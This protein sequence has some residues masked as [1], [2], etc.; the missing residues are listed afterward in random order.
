M[1]FTVNALKVLERRYLKKDDDGRPIERPEDMFWRVAY[2]IA[3]VDKDYNENADVLAVAKDFFFL[4]ANMEFMPNSPTLMNA[5][6]ELG[7]LSA[8]FVLPVE[9][10]M[11]SI[12]EAVKNTALIHKSG[13]GTGFSFSRIRP[14]NDMVLSTKGI[15]SGPI[16]FMKVFDMATET[17]KQGGTRRGAN[18]GI[19]RVDHPDILEFIESKENESQLNNFNISVAVTD[20]FME[21]CESDGEYDLINPRTREAVGRLKAREVFQKIV[22]HAWLNG[23]P[24]IIFLDRIN[25][26]NPTPLVGQ[27]ESTNPCGEQPLLPYESCNLGS[28]NLEKML[29]KRNSHYEVDFPRLART[30]RTAVHFLDNVIDTNKYPLPK[31]AEMTRANRKIGLGVMGFADMLIR[32]GIPY[33]SE[34]ALKVADELMAFIQNKAHDESARIAETRGSFPNYDKSIYAGSGRPMRNATV[35]TVA[36]TGTI[37]IIS[38][39][40]SGIEPI[41]AIAFTRHVLDN[42]ELI[43]AHPIFRQLAK[44][45][46]FFSPQLMK[47]IAEAGGMADLPE[48]PP[49]IKGVFVTAH[50]VTPEWHIKMQAAFQVH[51]DNAV[52]KTVNFANSATKEDVEN[53]YTLAYKLGCKGVTIFRDGSRSGQVWTKSITKGQAAPQGNDIIPRLRQTVT[54]GTTEKVVIG[55]GNLYVTVNSDEIG[56]CEVFTSTGRA[57]GCPSQSEATSRLVSLALRSGISV[58]A[59]IEQLKG[60]RC[61][62]TVA[63]KRINPDIRCLSCPDAIG[64]AIEKYSKI[65]GRHA[66]E[67]PNGEVETEAAVEPAT[68]VSA[69][70]DCG[71]KI[72]REGGCIVCRMCGYSKCN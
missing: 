47:K 9:D 2:T 26:G 67:E 70:P 71:A 16:S 45:R 63:A 35:T 37:S 61:L 40:S 25:K 36:P 12:F 65:P 21:A 68:A 69:C 31:I 19:L 14:K 24:G 8:C 39:C 59:L 66:I 52:S 3:Q 11:E 27:I 64:R 55:C 6:R 43:E 41:F 18:M 15:S 51:T 7:Q 49:E 38:G 60:I 54:Q 17:I 72:E 4:M 56:I 10:S 1:E 33:N 53:V 44:E 29:I 50:E 13:G 32:M 46:G 28:I 57:G 62:S 20:K 58:D 23:D 30:V 48:V 42:D 5:G 22:E 34:Q